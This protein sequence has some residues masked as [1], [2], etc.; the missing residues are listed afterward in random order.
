MV[1]GSAQQGNSVKKF[2]IDFDQIERNFKSRH[3]LDIRDLH[4]SGSY[5]DRWRKST[6]EPKAISV[7]DQQEQYQRYLNDP[8]G[9]AASPVYFDFWHW[10]L[11]N[12]NELVPW[13]ETKSSRSKA[14]PVGVDIIPEQK[15]L[16]PD[17]E[18][19]AYNRL[20]SACGGVDING[21][22]REN[23]NVMVRKQNT[24]HA[25]AK[26]VVEMLCRDY[27]VDV[28]WINMKVSR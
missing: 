25:D 6:G 19:A 20:L 21:I 11:D 16:T 27:G 22:I 12:Y 14:V 24:Q 17:E 15:I 23:I 18:T 4:R 8:N 13:K 7:A 28:I 26:R 5:Y 9:N 1:E 2:V 3:N 10:L